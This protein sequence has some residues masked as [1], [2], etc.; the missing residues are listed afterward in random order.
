[1]GNVLFRS[2]ALEENADVQNYAYHSKRKRCDDSSSDELT[3]AVKKQRKKR[4]LGN[5][6]QYIYNTLF[7]KGENSD[8]TICAFDHEWKLHKLYLCQ[9]GYF[10]GMFN[11][12]WKE[13]SMQVITLTKFY[14]VA[15]Y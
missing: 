9:A 1:M 6:S 11:S 12:N 10:A 13:S 3:Y 4:K 15:V 7:V 2:H 8:V 14:N 5:T